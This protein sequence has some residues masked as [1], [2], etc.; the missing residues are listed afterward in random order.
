MQ[1]SVNRP[2]DKGG[3]PSLAQMLEK[4]VEILSMRDEGYFL[5]V[6]GMS[7][8]HVTHE[9]HTGNMLSMTDAKLIGDTK[10]RV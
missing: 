3:E 8:Q 1:Y 5:F 10:Y 4:A 7:T 9:Y 2:S 6:E